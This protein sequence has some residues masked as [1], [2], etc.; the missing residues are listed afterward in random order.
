MPDRSQTAGAST[1]MQCLELRGG[2]GAVDD[3]LALPGI[4]LW[5]VSRPFADSGVGGDVHYVSTCGTGRISRVLLADVSGHG[6]AV[7]ELSDRLHD[8]MARHINVLDQRKLFRTLNRRLGQII[9]DGSF[10]TAVMLTFFAPTGTLSVSS[11][12]HPPP[13]L[14][15]GRQ[16]QWSLLSGGGAGDARAMLNLPLG[17]IDA[18]LYDRFNVALG[19][20][21]LVLCYTDCVTESRGRDGQL[22]SIQGL[23]EVAQSIDGNDAPRVVPEFLEVLGSLWPGNLTQ[24]DLTMLAF[25]PNGGA[26]G[27]TLRRHLDA[28]RL[29]ARVLWRR[30]TRRGARYAIPWPDL[31]LANTGGYLVSWFNRFW[32]SDNTS[33]RGDSSAR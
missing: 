33:S 18:A 29:A 12:G 25:R 1:A 23:L 26:R 28:P 8:L 11:A 20:E 32:N 16:R 3:S 10:A 17:V 14:W 27:V 2:S 9:H 22:L 13:L 5:V 7:G 19:E 21:D 31:N 30:L 6:A 4:D 24:D 15:R